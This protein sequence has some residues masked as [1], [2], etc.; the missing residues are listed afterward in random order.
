L[1]HAPGS[2]VSWH[3]GD[4]RSP[5]NDFCKAGEI[6]SHCQASLKP[7]PVDMLVF[8]SKH[9]SAGLKFKNVLRLRNYDYRPQLYYQLQ[10]VA[11]ANALQLETAKCRVSRSGL[12]WLITAHEL[13]PFK[14]LKF[15]VGS[16]CFG[17]YSRWIMVCRCVGLYNR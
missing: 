15:G 2:L 14:D 11:I 5:K 7:S 6:I 16:H 10:N 4:V 17:L 8:F 9:I 12:F 13:Q 1:T 3:S